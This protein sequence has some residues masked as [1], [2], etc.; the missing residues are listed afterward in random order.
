MAYWRAGKQA[1]S[2]V[3]A[4]VYERH[5]PEH[6]LFFQFVQEYYP[7]FKTQ[8]GGAEHG[9]AGVC[10]AGARGLPQMRPAPL[11]PNLSTRPE[12]RQQALHDALGISDRP[13]KTEKTIV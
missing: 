12:P 11:L 10:R 1:S 6:T 2:G 7:A 9:L 4:H 3:G 8:L 13:G 5:R